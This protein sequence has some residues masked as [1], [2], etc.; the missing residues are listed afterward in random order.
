MLLFQAP[1]NVASIKKSEVLPNGWN[2]NSDFYTLLYQPHDSDATHLLKVVKMDDTLLLHVMVS[3]KQSTSICVIHYSGIFIFKQVQHATIIVKIT[4]HVCL[5][6][7]MN[8][9]QPIWS[10][11]GWYTYTFIY[12][13]PCTL[14][15]IQRQFSPCTSI[16]TC[17]IPPYTSISTINSIWNVIVMIKHFKIC[18]VVQKVDTLQPPLYIHLYYKYI[19]IKYLKV[20]WFFGL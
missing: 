20:A 3:L 15:K 13:P 5:L 8:K 17:T 11:L 4:I 10:Y 12:I 6:I 1:K 9:F 19:N 16:T 14:I 2:E 7:F 18:K